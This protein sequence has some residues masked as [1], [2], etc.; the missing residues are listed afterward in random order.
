MA[1][2][3]VVKA[4]P[5]IE[6]RGHRIRMLGRISNV[7]ARHLPLW[8]EGSRRELILGNSLPVEGRGNRNG[9]SSLLRRQLALLRGRAE[10]CPPYQ[11]WFM[12]GEQVLMEQGA[13]PEPA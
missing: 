3:A 6:K 9:P 13:F 2:C 10:D 1:R 11:Y 12:G 4:T 7:L 8:F 5:D